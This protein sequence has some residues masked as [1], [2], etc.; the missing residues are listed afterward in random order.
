MDLQVTYSH[1]YCAKCRKYFSADLSG[2][3]PP[4]SHYTQR[5]IELA[6]R[7]VSEDGLPY[8]AASWHLWRDHR[9][10]VPW[11]TLQ[12]WVEAGGKKGGAGDGRGVSGRGAGRVLR[13][14]RG[15]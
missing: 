13:L 6:V 11:G 12:N 9:V 7:V 4:Y 10:F 15:R 2:L 8:R 3:A 14:P 5:V 1:H